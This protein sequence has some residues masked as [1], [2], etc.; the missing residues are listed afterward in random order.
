MGR[1]RALHD[2][3]REPRR[4]RLHDAALGIDQHEDGRVDARMV[5]YVLDEH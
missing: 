1:D 5:A 4:P 3:R 2:R